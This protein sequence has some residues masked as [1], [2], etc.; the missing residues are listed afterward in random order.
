ME[1]FGTSV[2]EMAGVFGAQGLLMAL[3]LAVGQEELQENIRIDESQ[4]NCAKAK[5]GAFKMSLYSMI[6]F[7]SNSS[8]GKLIYTD[9]KQMN[10]CMSET[11]EKSYKMA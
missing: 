2:T 1:W 8:K 3:S 6:T 11:E 4:N 9:R 10:V 5:P 7:I